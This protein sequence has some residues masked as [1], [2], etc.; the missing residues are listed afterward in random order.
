M[1]LCK[2]SHHTKLHILITYT[3]YS[4]TTHSL[5]T[6]HILKPQTLIPYRF[7]HNFTHTLIS[8]TTHPHPSHHTHPHPSLFSQGSA[9]LWKWESIHPPHF[10]LGAS[11][12]YEY[13]CWSV[14]VGSTLPEIRRT[15]PNTAGPGSIEE[16][17]KSR[18]WDMKFKETLHF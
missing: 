14:W 10:I 8:H 3:S 7:P 12:P 15:T 17:Y 2:L 11:D 9:G 18:E 16:L 6:W 13:I 5:Y 4:H 1:G